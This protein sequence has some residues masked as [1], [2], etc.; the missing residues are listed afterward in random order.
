MF[1]RRQVR[2]VSPSGSWPTTPDGETFSGDIAR[3]EMFPRR[4]C[5][6]CKSPPRRGNIFEGNSKMFPRRGDT[7]P[8]KHPTSQTCFPVGVMFPRRGEPRGTEG[9]S[10][11]GRMPP[12]LLHQMFPRRGH[13]HCY[14]AKKRRGELN[15]ETFLCS[16]GYSRRWYRSNG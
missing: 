8:A 11:W 2:N 16:L 5:G 3:G 6:P 9:M 7:F 14:L 4:A 12:P 1:P 13:A 10:A 15:G